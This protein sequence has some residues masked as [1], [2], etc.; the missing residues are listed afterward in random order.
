MT[1]LELEC[2]LISHLNPRQ[3]II[4]PNVSDLSLILNFEADILQLSRDNYANAYE[5]K[6]SKYDLKNDLN[7]RHIR[8]LDRVLTNG[9]VAFD[10]FY[11][12]LKRFMYVVPQELKQDALNQIPDFCGLIVASYSEDIEGKIE[13]EMIKRPKILNRYKWTDWERSKLGHLGAMRILALKKNILK[14]RRSNFKSRNTQPIRF[15]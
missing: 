14:E 13:F 6:V 9:E 15:I 2:A 4:V 12:P 1:T 5:L 8:D 3:N 11:K 7:K 10:F